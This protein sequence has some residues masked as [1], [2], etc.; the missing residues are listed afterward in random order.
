MLQQNSTQNKIISN[1]MFPE[2]SVKYNVPRVIWPNQSGDMK[3]GKSTFYFTEKTEPVWYI[4]LLPPAVI[5]VDV[6]GGK[7]W[8]K[9]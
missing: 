7:G 8:G 6:D 4:Y 5:P 1:I 3:L 9:V 2:W